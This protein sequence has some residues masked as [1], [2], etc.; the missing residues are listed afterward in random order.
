MTSLEELDYLSTLLQRVADV[1]LELIDTT[2]EL[3]HLEHDDV[4]LLECM[5][6]CEFV[7]WNTAPTTPKRSRPL[8]TRPTRGC[9]CRKS[10]CLK[11]YCVCYTA[12]EACTGECRCTGCGNY[13]S[14]CAPRAVYEHCACK[15][16]SCGTKYCVCVQAGRVCGAKCR[17]D[18][19][20]NCTTR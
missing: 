5:D 4:E 12:G 18:G 16:N 2:Q 7:S 9:S 8:Y 10:R 13:E 17:C 3:V 19:C 14:V 1:G 6:E 15:R 20:E 11:L